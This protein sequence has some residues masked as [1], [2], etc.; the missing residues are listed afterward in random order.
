M[1][2]RREAKREESM[3]VFSEAIA[4]MDGETTG[5]GSADTLNLDLDFRAGRDDDITWAI[6]CLV[7]ASTGLFVKCEQASWCTRIQNRHWSRGLQACPVAG[8]RS[9]GGGSPLEKALSISTHARTLSSRT[10]SPFA[11]PDHSFRASE[12]RHTIRERAWCCSTARHCCRWLG[13]RERAR[14]RK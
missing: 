1:L 5:P 7:T 10:T 8:L 4:R 9:V 11:R 13:D 14:T 12:R 2:L 3:S 6:A